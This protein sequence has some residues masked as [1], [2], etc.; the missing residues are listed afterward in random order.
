M[1]RSA[2]L[3][4]MDEKNTEV[5]LCSGGAGRC[6]CAAIG[7]IAAAPPTNVMNSRRLTATPKATATAS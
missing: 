2:E 5:K 4:E 3:P 7:Q 6:A 1:K